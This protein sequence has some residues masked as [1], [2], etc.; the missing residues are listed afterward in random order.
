MREKNFKAHYN[1][2]YACNNT[3]ILKMIFSAQIKLNVQDILCCYETPLEKKVLA[4][5]RAPFR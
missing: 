2:L 4:F 5:Q 3:A 1:S